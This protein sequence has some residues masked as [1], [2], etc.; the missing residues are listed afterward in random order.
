MNHDLTSIWATGQVQPG[1]Q[2]GEDYAP[3]CMAHPAKMWPHIAIE[4]IRRYSSHGETVLD[5]MCG[6]GTTV[7]EAVKMGRYGL[8]VEYEPRWAQ[9]ADA[10]LRRSHMHRRLASEIRCADARFL[11]TVFPGRSVDLVVTSPPYGAFAHGNPDKGPQGV[12]KADERYTQPR[13]HRRAQLATTSQ[14]RIHEGLQAIF[15]QC[16]AMLRAGGY[17]VITARPYKENGILHDFPSVV[18]RCALASGFQLQHRD[19]ALL[20]RWDGNRLRPHA[21]FFH[22]HNSRLNAAA[23]KPALIRAHEDVLVF[24]KITAPTTGDPHGTP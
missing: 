8:G 1:R 22:I 6:I 3:S 21:T 12:V 18:I 17:M 16:H 2:R 4:A 10:S 13:Y 11:S 24:Q 14:K 23:G 9:A 15:A 7:I 5:P 20:A 19:V